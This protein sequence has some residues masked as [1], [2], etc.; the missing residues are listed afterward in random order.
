M[1]KTPLLIFCALLL[2]GSLHAKP[3]DANSARQVAQA[4]L[5]RVEGGKTFILTDITSRTPYTE[6]HVFSLGE[7]GF[8]LVSGDDCAVPIL[9][10]SLTSRFETEGMPENA[11]A[12]LEDYELEIRS[13]KS[14]LGPDNAPA[15]GWDIVVDP[16]SIPLTEE[17]VSPLIATTWNQTGYYNKRCPTIGSSRAPTGCVATAAAQLMRFWQHPASG[18]GSHSYTHS[19]AGTLSANFDTVYNW[20]LMPNALGSSSSTAQD[21]EVSKLM[22]HI[23]VAVEMGYGASSS[24]A[25]SMNEAGDVRVSAQTALMKYFKYSPAMTAV[26][27]ENFTTPQWIALLKAELDASRPIYYTGRHTSGGHAFICDGYNNS[28]QF[29]FNW[30]WG[31][32]LDAYFTIGSLNPGTGGTGG[33]SSGT[34]NMDNAAL[35]GVQPYTG[36][37]ATGGTVSATVNGCSGCSIL[38]TGTY[39]FGD[40]VNLRPSASSGYRFA[41]WETGCIDGL[42]SFLPGGGNYSFT[43]QFEPLS[44]DTLSYCGNRTPQ[45]NFRFGTTT[46]WGIKIPASCL[47][48]GSELRA[49]QLYVAAAGNHIFKAYTSTPSSSSPAATTTVNYT[50]S[51][52][53]G[54]QT[55][56]LSS[57]VA[58]DGTQDVWLTFEYSGGN[59]DYPVAV[60]AST[61]NN[62]GLLLG[63][64]LNSYH[65]A[66]NPY[67]CLIRGI[68]DIAE[69]PIVYDTATVPYYTGFE[70]NEDR[71]WTF[72]NNNPNKWHIGSTGGS[73]EMFISNNGGSSNAY[74]NSRAC[75]SFATRTFDL[76]AGLYNLG[77]AWQCYGESTWDFLRAFLCPASDTP[78][79]AFFNT[80]PLARTGVPTGWIDITGNYLNRRQYWSDTSYTF[81]V[82][83]SGY[84]KV[85]FMWRNDGSSGINPPA[86]VDNISLQKIILPAT[87]PYTTGFET[88]DDCDWVLTSASTNQ[89]HIGNAAQQSG[90]RA[91]YI[92]NDGGATNAYTNNSTS[93]SYAARTFTLNAGNYDLSFYWRYVGENN[94]DFMRLFLCPDSVDLSAS[95]F[96]INTPNVRTTVPTG[97]QDLH[98][99]TFTQ[100]N[101]WQK[102][103]Y[104]F[105]AATAGN[106]KLVFLW[107]NDYG[108]GSNPPAA[109]DSVHLAV[110]IQQYTITATSANNT[111]GTVTGGG[112]Y[113]EGAS[114]TLT[115]TANTGYHFV[116][117]NDGNTQNPRTVT[118]TANA[119]YTATFA[120]NSYTITANSA[121]ATMGTVSGGGSYDYNSTATLTATPASGYHFVQWNDGNTQNPRTVTVTA[122]AT[123]TAT[124]APNSYTLTATSAD[125]TMGSVSGGGTYDYNST[126][127][128]TATAITGYHFVQWNDGNTQN[129][130]TVTVTGNATYT[131]TFAPN[132]YTITATSADAT[133]GSVSGGGSYDYNSTA[134]LTA[135]AA[136]G[137]HFVQW[138]DGNTQNPRTVTVTGNATYTATFEADAPSVNYYSVSV[139]TADASMGS[140][141]S[142]HSGSVEESTSVTVTATAATGHSFTAWKEGSTQVSTSAAYT[143]SV[144][145]NISLTA[146]FAVNS[147]TVT[148]TSANTTMGTV[149]GGGSYDYNSTATLTATAATGHHFVQWQD[150]NTQNPRTVTVTGDATYTATFAPNSYTVTA[151]S[152]NNTMGSVSGGGSYDYNSTAT[153]TATPASGYHFVQWQDG[154]TQNPRTV[155]VTGDATY[156]AT[157]EANAPSVNYYNVSVSSADA[158]M[159]SVGSTHSGSVEEGTSI[160]VTATA[161]TGHSFVAWTDGT[162]QVSTA[163]P[164]TFTLTGDISLTATFAA[165]SYTLTVVSSDNTMGTVSGGGT[166]DYGATATLTATAHA[167]YHFVEWQDGNTQNPRTVTV[168]GDTTYTAI[169]EANATPVQQYII[170]VGSNDDAMGTVSGSGT[171]DEGTVVTL[172]ATPNAGYRFVRWD[173]GNTDN[174]RTVTVT[175]DAS[176]TAIFERE[177]GVDEVDFVGLSLYPNPATAEVHLAG[178][179]I[180]AVITLSDINGRTVV[181]TTATTLDV[182]GLVTGTYFVRI[183]TGQAT[184][185]RK[186]IVR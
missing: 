26:K 117:W 129:P 71:G 132:S 28:N 131:A 54:W 27:L 146:H 172:T 143:F 109:I 70:G 140:V 22:Y 164:Y 126:A 115:A 53:G 10:Y 52:M 56:T 136:S 16:N 155:T 42:R 141:S 181:K 173:D 32:N 160:T 98:G 166:Y 134:T 182:S 104:T 162:A 148:A 55:I 58:L 80:T 142:T 169:F 1:K 14:A 106:Y 94:Y 78:D 89:W 130:R 68:F 97:W 176:Y 165:N 184:A 93:L 171:Y 149:S 72:V 60:C 105:Q 120:P 79:A 145:R 5:S 30:G 90:A 103:S 24:G 101:A 13:L 62:D 9:G 150:G 147:Y 81:N 151:T 49:V 38:G 95:H 107:Y 51:H 21:N 31:G 158:T 44:G 39:S 40:T 88:T 48:S 144:T 6:F 125:A 102:S 77:F 185:I 46:Q 85:V 124:F 127:T 83:T 137:H 186:L 47:P 113:N 43:A 118:V 84:Y 112:T 122:A 61:G 183:A 110:H 23:G 4:F 96:N 34:Y 114:A 36:T 87:L 76:S 41:R 156:T 100:N 2:C 161:A 163:N 82:S 177:V 92:S 19:S 152:A 108:D 138:N 167:G 75:I 119:T 178:V 168:T 17:A 57:P 69:I 135:T 86:A 111:M 65:N 29:H 67:T 128:L 64:S 174:P 35:L 66:F 179:P 133:M 99:G 180:G 159:G 3:V 153:L 121:D 37:F 11:A 73:V 123:Y 157:F 15:P 7:K 154:N 59:N 8:V 50:S 74:T 116:Q 91:L 18:Y 33:N 25:V 175:A 63:S 170:A 20:S 45:I 12:W 139:A